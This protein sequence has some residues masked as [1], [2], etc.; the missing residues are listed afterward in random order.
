[1]LVSTCGAADSAHKSRLTNCTADPLKLRKPPAFSFATIHS[2]TRLLPLFPKQ[3][4]AMSPS[5][6]SFTSV[7]VLLLALFVLFSVASAASVIPKDS[8]AHDGNNAVSNHALEPRQTVEEKCLKRC[9]EVYNRCNHECNRAYKK[10][11]NK[12][13]RCFNDCTVTFQNC[14]SACEGSA[15]EAT[16]DTVDSEDN[17]DGD[18]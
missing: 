1:M 16:G 8:T 7:I 10:Y 2:G 6:K 5:T 3:L 13:G 12:L 11:P 9:N 18:S 17:E 15:T 14:E 4:T